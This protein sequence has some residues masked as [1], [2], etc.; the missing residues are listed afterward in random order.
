MDQ[1]LFINLRRRLATRAIVGFK[2]RNW[3][4]P[5][6]ELRTF[7]AAKSKVGGKPPIK[8]ESRR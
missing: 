1:K 3:A 4:D 7:S 2:T 5:S 8:P 6:A